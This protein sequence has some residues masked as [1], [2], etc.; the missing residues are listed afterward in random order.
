MVDSAID[1]LVVMASS[2]G[3]APTS[4][5]NVSLTD[6]IRGKMWSIHTGSG[7]PSVAQA[8]TYSWRYRWARRDTGPR[9]ALIR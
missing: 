8:S 2:P 1:T 4:A 9:E 3:S 6:R 5:A 7:A